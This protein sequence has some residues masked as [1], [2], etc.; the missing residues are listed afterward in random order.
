VKGIG[1]LVGSVGNGIS[2]IVG[3]ALDAIAA[4]AAAIWT[5][6]T[7]ALPGPLLPIA[8]VALVLGLGFLVFRR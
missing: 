4:T 6:A 2:T 3:H 5:G 1:D 7:T 8:I